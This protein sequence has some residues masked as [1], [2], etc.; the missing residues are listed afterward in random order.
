MRSFIHSFQSEWLKKKRSLASWIVVIGGFFTPLI[1]I[2]AR[3]VHHDQLPQLY[4]NPGFWVQLWNNS[5]ESMA[6]FLLPVGVIMATS[7]VTQ[8]EYKNNTWK[9]LH[10]VPLRLSTIF[11][12]KLS[13]ILVMMIQFFIL[14]N[15]GIY[16]SALVPYLLVGGVSYPQAPIPLKAFARENGLFFIDCLPVLAI[17][18]LLGLR[19]KNFLIPIGAGFLCWILAVAVISWKYGYWLPYTYTMFNFLKGQTHGRAIVPPLNIHLL[20]ISY[21]VL[22]TGI[23]Y[24]L[25]ITKKEKG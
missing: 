2:I 7:L 5:W 4:S 19:Y 24:I 22:V 14:F 20:A 9:Q 6:I 15:I 13:V 21:F 16:L 12:S 10:T 17:Q 25:Y 3:L 8:L 18:Y 23:S 11:F 1:I